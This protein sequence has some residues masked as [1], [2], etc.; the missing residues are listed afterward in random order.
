MTLDDLTFLLAT[1]CAGSLPSNTELRAGCANVLT[2]TIRT[3]E[4]A[5]ELVYG[6]DGELE[7]RGL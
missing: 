4:G 6:E 7:L 5:I 3:D 2:C 1:K